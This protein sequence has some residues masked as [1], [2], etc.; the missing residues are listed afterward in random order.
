MRLQKIFDNNQTSWI[1]KHII[2]TFEWDARWVGI[3]IGMSPL[4]SVRLKNIFVSPMYYTCDVIKHIIALA[5]MLFLF[6]SPPPLFLLLLL[7]FHFILL[8]CFCC[9]S[10]DHM[11]RSCDHRTFMRFVFQPMCNSCV[12]GTCST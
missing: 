5:R 2:S 7:L 12:P 11:D 10:Y 6:P 1:N 3:C 4:E 9:D 8:F